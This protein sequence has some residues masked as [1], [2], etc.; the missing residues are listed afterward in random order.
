L[1]RLFTNLTFWVLT[2]IT[3]GAL[4]GHFYPEKGIEMD[5]LGKGFIQVVKVFI[6]PIIFLTITLGIIGMGDLKKVG[7]VGAKALL[8]FEVVT[9]LALIIGIV[10]ANLIRP[11]DGVVTGNLQKGDVAVYADKVQEFSWWQFFL[12]N[13]TLQVLLA[14]LIL[15]TVLSKY[16]GKDKIIQWLSFGSK[17]VFKA[18]HW[19]M[20]FAPIGAFGGM[21]YTIGKYGIATLIPLGKLMVTVYATMAIFIFLVLGFILNM[22]KIKI[23][24][25]LKY[26]R[27][28][29]LIVLG[30]SSS[31]AALPSIMEK[32][33]RMGCSKPVVG[34]VVPA[35]Y[36]FNLDGTTI[37]LSMATIFLAQVFDVHLTIGQMLSIVGILMVTSKGAAGVTGSGFVVLASTLTAIKV[38]PVEGLALLLGVDRFMSEA[39]AI[40]NII[41]NGVATIWLANNEN[42][43]DRNKMNYAFANVH[44]TENIIT[45]NLTDVTQE[46]SR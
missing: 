15:G 4:L 22:Y 5:F 31:E 43:F 38:I 44:E 28:E 30:T 11:G 33:E 35:G 26:I 21:A 40:T 39:R 24:S 37:Y 17:Y 10:V 25:F 2:A 8:Y 34:L 1:K 23:W 32:L 45:D 19:V 29:L 6:N 13:M 18:L 46:N 20:L 14:S 9:T 7:K 3:S 12:D 41:G 42:E 16:S 36:S 27:E